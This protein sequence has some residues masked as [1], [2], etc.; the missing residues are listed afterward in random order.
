MLDQQATWQRERRSA[1]LRGRHTETHRT[2]ATNDPTPG[3]YP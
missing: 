2:E 1:G 3:L